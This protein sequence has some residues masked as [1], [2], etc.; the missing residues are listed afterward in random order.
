MSTILLVF[1]ELSLFGDY[2]LFESYCERSANI[3][4]HQSIFH[5]SCLPVLV[6]YLFS[7]STSP[8]SPPN[9]A[10]AAE[11]HN[12]TSHLTTSHL[13]TSHLTTSHL[14]TSHLTTSHLISSHPT[15]SHHISLHHITSHQ[16]TSH[17]ISSHLTA[18]HLTTSHHFT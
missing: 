9:R 16:I 6:T 13:T 17:L 1:P 7:C 10:C 8:S 12:T 5:S 11:L 2:E 4:L 14:T 3:Y 18:S 15:T